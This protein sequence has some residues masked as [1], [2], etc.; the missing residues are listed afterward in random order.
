MYGK[1]SK[2]KNI[3]YLN[4]TNLNLRHTDLNIYFQNI[5][6]IKNKLNDLELLINQLKESFVIITFCE[7][8]KCYYS[9]HT[10]TNLITYTVI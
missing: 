8:K 3:N 9:V 5:A 4:F 2:A 1:F 10:V 7:T 6:A